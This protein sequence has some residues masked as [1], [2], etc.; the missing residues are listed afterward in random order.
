M[1]VLEINEIKLF[2][3]NGLKAVFRPIGYG[4][5][6]KYGYFWVGRGQKTPA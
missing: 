6:L 5:E 3:L 2:W 4:K 1:K